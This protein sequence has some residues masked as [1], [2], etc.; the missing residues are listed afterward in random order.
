MKYNYM[1]NICFPKD[2]ISVELS[3]FLK[4]KLPIIKKMLPRSHNAIN[5]YLP[6]NVHWR[7]RFQDAY[8]YLFCLNETTCTAELCINNLYYLTDRQSWFKRQTFIQ[9]ISAVFATETKNISV[10]SLYWMDLV[11]ILARGC[12]G[13]TQVSK[14]F[15]L[16][17]F[18]QRKTFPWWSHPH[19]KSIFLVPGL[20]WNPCLIEGLCGIRAYIGFGPIFIFFE[21]PS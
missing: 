6:E 17:N 19:S 20:S 8:V 9:H 21:G 5:R 14:S 13:F 3:G 18:F 15:E 11:T 4:K 2:I 12:N 10:F 1:Y 16:L 7:I